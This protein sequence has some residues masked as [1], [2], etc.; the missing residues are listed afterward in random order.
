MFNSTLK[1]GRRMRRVS[2]KTRARAPLRLRCIEAVMERAGRR[3]EAKLIGCE[4]VA[5]HVHELLPRSRGGDPTNPA[6][7]IA[8]CWICHKQIHDQPDLAASL[9]LT[10]SKKYEAKQ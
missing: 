6:D 8:A 3:C 1:R 5:V 2:A 10:I 7:C 9:G 4:T